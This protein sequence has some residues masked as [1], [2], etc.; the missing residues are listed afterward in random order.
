MSGKQYY[1]M[2]ASEE[3]RKNIEKIFGVKKSKGKY[4]K[5]SGNNGKTSSLKDRNPCDMTDVYGAY[6]KKWPC[7]LIDPK[8][9]KRD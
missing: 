9:R 7:S 4:S 1:D 5:K 3:Y 2:G 6:I 8:P